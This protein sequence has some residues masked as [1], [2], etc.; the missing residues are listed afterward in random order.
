[1][2]EFRFPSLL[3]L[4]QL[5]SFAWMPIG[6]VLWI[7][8]FIAAG[9]FF[10]S[11]GLSDEDFAKE[12]NSIWMSTL[13]TLL[14]NIL[15]GVG[16]IFGAVKANALPRQGAVIMGSCYVASVVISILS[17]IFGPEG[18]DGEFMNT[19]DIIPFLM[20]VILIIFALVIF[21]WEAFCSFWLLSSLDKIPEQK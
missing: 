7:L 14:P 5:Y 18:S 17:L 12:M 10:G 9:W 3:N 4:I 1:M 6:I 15:I 13:Y 16:L 8:F 2:S 19:P 20:V 21:A 11:G